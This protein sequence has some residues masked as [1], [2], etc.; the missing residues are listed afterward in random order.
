M[1]ACSFVTTTLDDVPRY[2]G[3][4]RRCL[5]LGLE[6]QIGRRAPQQRVGN[7]Q[8]QRKDA[9]VPAHLV[10]SALTTRDD[11]WMIGRDQRQ[12]G[13]TVRFIEQESLPLLELRSV[14][15]VVQ[16]VVTAERDVVCG[17]RHVR[18]PG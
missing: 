9:L 15:E 11:A 16:L 12:M 10:G 8:D 13:K 4:E 17:M 1:V 18:P 7:R 3:C 5:E 2:L 14:G 6:G